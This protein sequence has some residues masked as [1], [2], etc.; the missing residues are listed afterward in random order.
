[1]IDDG[2]TDWKVIAIDI[3]DPLADQLNDLEDVD[4]LLPGVMEST[5]QWFRTYKIPAGKPENV[6][7]FD[8]NWKGK[9]FTQELIVEN[10]DFWKALINGDKP[11][12]TDDYKIATQNTTLENGY[13]VSAEDAAAFV[14]T[15]EF[16]GLPAR[17]TDEYTLT[18]SKNVALEQR[19]KMFG[20][21]TLSTVVGTLE[22]VGQAVLSAGFTTEHDINA[23][24]VKI[25]DADSAIGMIAVQG[26]EP[27]LSDYDKEGYVQP[28]LVT[29]SNTDN[30]T[31]FG[32]YE[33][34]REVW[35][36]AKDMTV[37]ELTDQ[38]G[39]DL[40]AAGFITYA[41]QGASFVFATPA[42]VCTYVWD[43]SKEVF[44]LM[45]TGLKLQTSG[46]TV[47]IG[48]DAQEG[49]VARKAST[50]AADTNCILNSGG[51][52]A[53]NGVSLAFQAAPLA[54]V[55]AVAGGSNQDANEY[56]VLNH[57]LD[58]TGTTDFTLGN[59]NC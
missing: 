46:N 25:L 14:P 12:E 8:G 26:Q 50:L 57:S 23:E 42:S 20:M 55:V 6:F 4:R 33:R 59:V 44:V 48:T 2:E 39:A 40:V 54:F 15:A 16:V 45:K 47:A 17:E 1:M 3:N 28:F 18:P 43:I 36:A 29:V 19:A 10:Y 35:N 53:A 52:L 58:L 32:L 31:I 30:S 13:T 9:E 24:I 7:G 49:Q 21:S 56:D 34:P 37:E 41:N 22:K 51:V 5:Y 27:V 38:T 11:N